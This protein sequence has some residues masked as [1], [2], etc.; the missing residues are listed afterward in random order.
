ML[1]QNPAP[2]LMM[3]NIQVYLCV[4]QVVKSNM[5]V[6]A[7][8]GNVLLTMLMGDLLLWRSV[9]KI[10]HLL[11]LLT[12]ATQTLNYV[13]LTLG[14]GLDNLI[15]SVSVKPDVKPSSV[16]TLQRDNVR[17]LPTEITMT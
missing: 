14:P 1:L 12:I 8:T 10:V 16:V 9:T 3:D 13:Q 6:T 11:V 17:L 5:S 4:K 15:L 7:L 2:Q